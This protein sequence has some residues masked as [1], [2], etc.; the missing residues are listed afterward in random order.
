VPESLLAGLRVVDLGHDPSA[1][2]A[3]I[4]GDLGAAVT[5]IV[6][7]TGDP[8]AGNVARAWNAGKRVVALADDAADLDAVLAEADVVFD[9]PGAPGTHQ[10]DPSRAPNA[11]WVSITPFGLE[12]PRSGWRASDLGVMAA[13]GNMYCTGDPDRPPVRCTEPT[14]Y[15]HTGAEAAF[16]ALT[17]VWTGVPQ[18]V[19]VSMQE[20]V[21][22]ANMA[23]PARFPQTGFRGSRR[24]ANIGKTREIWPTNDGFVSFGLRGGKARV[25]SLELI[26]KLAGLPVR[27]WTDF[28]PNTA[29]DEELA[30]IEAAVRAYF[31]NHSMQELYE[32]ACETNLMLAPI[33]SPREIYASVQL[34]ARNFFGPVDDVE[35]FPRSFVVVRSADAE[36]APARPHGQLGPSPSSPRR[37]PFERSTTRAWDGV[38]ILEFGSGAAGPI[39][40]RYF[41]EHGATVLR[42]ESKSRPDFLRVYA[43]GPDNPHGLEGAPM[44]DGL[45]VGKRNVTLNLKQTAAVELVRRL[46]VEWADA[47]AENFAP[48]AMKGFG[49]DYDALS[50]IKPDLVMVSACLNGQTGPH[51]DYPGFGGQGSALAGYNALTG[52]PDR[53]PVGPHATITDSLAPR[54]V[55]SAL[56]AGLHYR[57]RTGHGVY[58]DV[59]Q[60]ESATWSLAPWLLDY[61]HDGSLRLRDGNNHRDARLHGVFPCADEGEVRDRWV[62][63]AC[64]TDDDLA[65][66]HALAGTDIAAWTATRTRIDVA[67]QLQG[68]GIEAV[69]VQDFGDLHEDPQLTHRGHFEEHT[70]PFLGDGLY[71][72][73]GFRLSACPSGYDQA[74]PTLGQDT[75]WVLTK[76]LDLDIAAC[77]ALRDDGAVE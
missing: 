45:N 5:R 77:E 6:P 34:A 50:A 14:G 49:L 38:K 35:R 28:S 4:L 11:V 54:F 52:W 57:A 13:S 53:E 27:D 9:A 19:D 65:R 58:L 31:A 43:L 25:P 70:H 40:T 21:L 66:L 2:A 22:I 48:R 74:G 68:A 12:G 55:A 63:I 18:R 56:A 47:V 59:S 15:A 60:V 46:V 32:L 1:R 37:K 20:V 62:A 71:E 76:L 42:V 39:A 69:P 23:T 67:Q 3:R 61:E 72:R 29:S 26:S 24:G 16:A 7:P 75:D 17:A 30:A 73:N 33:N 44:Y 36:A 8:L 41:A 10:L 64:W 51:R